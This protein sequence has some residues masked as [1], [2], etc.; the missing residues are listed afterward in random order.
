MAALGERLKTLR[1]RWHLTQEELAQTLGVNAST[2]SLYEADKREPRL[3]DVCKMADYFRVATDYL[4]GRTDQPDVTPV[5]WEDRV[6]SLPALKEVM[7]GKPLISDERIAFWVKVPASDLVGGDYVFLVLERMARPHGLPILGS[8]MALI[9]LGS[10]FESGDLALVA[11]DRQKPAVVRR[12]YK[13]EG[14]VLVV[15][16]LGTTRPTAV[17]PSDLVVIGVVATL[18]I[19]FKERGEF[20]RSVIVP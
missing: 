5:T 3:D 7:A 9:Q 4:L 13:H 17:K 18:T 20:A 16:E 12:L 14:L 1:T 19:V 8:A 15:D 10:E 2:V 11:I 6:V